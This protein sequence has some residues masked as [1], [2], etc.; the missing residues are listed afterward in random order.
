M[1]FIFE[2]KIISGIV[3]FFVLVLIHGLFSQKQTDDRTADLLDSRVSARQFRM[4]NNDRFRSEN[5]VDR[6][7]V[8]LYLVPIALVVIGLLQTLGVL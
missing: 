3:L 8:V 4:N 7:F 2:H 1:E 6:I 5:K